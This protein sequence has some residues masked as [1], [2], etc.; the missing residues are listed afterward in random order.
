M[1][2]H[3]GT[4]RLRSHGAPRDK[5]QAHTALTVETHGSKPLE[6]PGWGAG[7]S[8]SIQRTRFRGALG[9]CKLNTDLTGTL[10]RDK[11]SE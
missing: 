1:R 5:Y 11:L 3:M 9:D 7:A 6:A 8:N 10:G 4:P 2:T